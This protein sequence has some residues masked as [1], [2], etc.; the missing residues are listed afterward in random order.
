M[1]AYTQYTVP[2]AFLQL[3]REIRDH[4][5]E[6]SELVPSR[7]ELDICEP[8]GSLPWAAAYPTSPL[9]EVCLQVQAEVLELFHSQNH[10]RFWLGR[11]RWC[12]SQYMFGSFNSTFT[13][14]QFKSSHL[15]SLRGIKQLY[16]NFYKGT[17]PGQIIA[18]ELAA[19]ASLVEKI[20]ICLNRHSQDPASDQFQ[21]ALLRFVRDIQEQVP[22]V[23]TIRL[24]HPIA[25]EL[26]QRIAKETSLQIEAI[27]A[28]ETHDECDRKLPLSPETFCGSTRSQK[29]QESVSD[30][31][32]F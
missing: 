29:V 18:L 32:A 24:A 27:C 8:V 13:E 17:G 21:T 23:H 16:L 10:F 14:A 2:S 6:L 22:S 20:R 28:R 5:Y 26:A 31:T 9:F 7:C 4:V 11:N 3:P 1:D 30:N 25:K 12:G 19:S 15:P